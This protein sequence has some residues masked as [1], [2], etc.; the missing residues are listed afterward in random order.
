VDLTRFLLAWRTIAMRDR[1]VIDALVDPAHAAPSPELQH[2][3]ARWPGSWY[4]SDEDG[5]RH[6]VLTRPRPGVRGQNWR[7][8]VLL[9]LATL[10]TTSWVGAAFAGRLP[11]MWFGLSSGIGSLGDL[12][13]GLSAGLGFSIPLTAILL[14]HEMGHY[15]AARAYHLDVSLP[16]FL[17]VPPVPGLIG[18]LGAF[19]RLRTIVSDRRQLFEVGVAGP[20]AGFLV[21]VPVLALGLAWSTPGIRSAGMVAS[22]GTPYSLGDSLVTL[23]MRAALLPDTAGVSLH[24]MAFAGWL[25]MFVTMLNLLPIAQLDG[26]H[27]LYAALPR[28]HERVALAFL[29]VILVLGW[30]SEWPGWW[31]FGAFVVV[32]SRGRLGHPPVLD[33]YRPMPRSRRWLAWVALA[34]FLVTFT[35][36]PFRI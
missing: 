27:I 11:F 31:V 13:R 6:L 5:H 16:Y 21:A 30:Y 15:V 10:L 1:E 29:G 12:L 14:A 35:P 9:F 18:T 36:V 24:P 7:L 8:H 22:L 2:A 20:I 26:G 23:A 32:L 25:G 34:L 17:P 28:W 4:W 3:L 19:I 33:A